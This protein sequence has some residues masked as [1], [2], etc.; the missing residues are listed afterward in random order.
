MKNRFYYIIMMLVLVSCSDF[1][2]QEPS[3]QRSIKE[4][5]STEENIDQAVNGLYYQI[6]GVLS[7][8]FFIYADLIGGNFTFTPQ[9]HDHVLEVPTA[10]AI[11]QVYDFNDKQ[12]E[13]DY[14]SFYQDMYE[15]INAAN[16][17]LEYTQG[18]DFV[19]ADKLT[20][21][22][23]ESL[24]IRAFCHY[25]LSL[26][27]AQQYGYTADASHLGIVYNTHT[28]VAGEDYPTRETMSRTW[29][30]IQADMDEA[31]KSFTS[32]SALGY[33]PDYSWFNSF[34]TKALYAKMALQM[35]DWEKAYEY[36]NDVILNS[37]VNLMPKDDYLQEWV[38]PAEAVSE[39]LLEFSAPRTAEEGEIRSSVGLSWFN[40]IDEN[41]YQ[42]I[43]ASGDLLNL[44]SESDIRNYLY[45]GIDIKTRIDNVDYMLPYYF[46]N[47]F[48]GEPGTLYLRLSEM[49]LIRAE[50]LARLGTDENAA[51]NDLNT[52]RERAGLDALTTTEN[53]LDEIFDERRRELAFEGNLFFDI[54]RYKKD[55][56]RNEG[57][58]SRVCNMEYPSNYFVLP[59]PGSSVTLNENMIQNN[60]Y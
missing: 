1:L 22:K 26:F 60:G 53:L 35:N 56:E 39:V 37:G 33:G 30:L 8:K 55:V 36:A 2:D 50:A 14:S 54:V 6:E 58:M 57:C 9:K 48:Q 17:V 31:L 5:F 19:S 16:L 34:N 25:L 24:A 10:I 42:E 7:H 49:Y 20:Q 11:D 41:N 29:E 44:F 32:E 46:T 18:V 28:I 52:I 59:I 45:V 23:A 3:E 4:Q 15:L 21:I 27:Y 40:Y 38:K 47:K 12:D 51:L 43:V 13:S